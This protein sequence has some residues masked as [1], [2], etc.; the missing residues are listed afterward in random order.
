MID[1][2][3]MGFGLSGRAFHAPVIR[4]V[5][6]LR[7]AAI[8]QRRGNEAAE[9]YP[10]ARVVRSV[11]E[12][13][14]MPQIRLI[15]IATP[16][17]THFALARRCLDAGRD[18]V[19]DKPFTTTLQEAAELVKF[20]A[21]RKRLLTVYH[22]RRWDADFQAIRQLLASGALGR[23]V[24]FETNYDRFRP[25]L[26]PNAWR[27]CPGPGSGILC[28]LGPHLTDHALVLFG[29]PEAIVADVRIEREGA[30]TDDAFDIVF[31]YPDG[32]RA[33]LR[34]TMLGAAPRPR[35]ILHGTQAAYVK[36]T[37]DPLE[38]AL[39]AGQIPVSDSWC[40]ESEEN[41]GILSFHGDS[42]AV[43][44]RIPSFGDWRDFYANVRDAMLGR[45]PLLVTSQQIL[46]VMRVLGIARESSHQRCTFPW[47]RTP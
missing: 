4:A 29:R 21:E 19:V 25:Q 12:L 8:L 1:V 37:F 13:L 22:N 7:L 31:D 45:A 9:I 44:R 2:A 46:D 14:A 41:Y 43:P 32:L 30:V 20:A 38:P 24:R 26:K 10:D 18:V 36:T 6:G 39:R 27:E 16:N 40:L 34:A 17:D 28:D 15:V 11:D 23:I 42:N 3:L 47:P 33:H 5:P 35:F